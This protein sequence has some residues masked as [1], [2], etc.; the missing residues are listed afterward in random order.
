MTTTSTLQYQVHIAEPVPFDTTEKAP[1]GDPRMFQPI[2]ST[3]IFG[4][5]E[6]VLVDPPMTTEQTAHVAKRIEDSGKTLKHIYITHGHGDHWFGTAPLLKHFP[7]ASVFASPGT[8]EVM[9]Y[10]ASPEVRAI[11]W[12]KNFPNQ[13]PDSPVV[14]TTPPGNKFELEGNELRI[15]EVGHTDT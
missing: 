14:A 8:I 4:D 5:T 10:H 15:V 12:D 6:A 9:H 2:S 11:V 1:N 13:I 7:N 3:L